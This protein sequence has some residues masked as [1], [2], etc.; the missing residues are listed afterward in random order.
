MAVLSIAPSLLQEDYHGY[1]EAAQTRKDALHKAGRTF[2]HKLA[3]EAGLPAGSYDIRSNRGGIAVS[4]EVTLH[5]DHLYVQLSEMGVGYEG[6]DVLYRS[7]KTRQDYVGG[8]NHFASLRELAKHPEQLA[9]FIREC[10]RLAQA[11]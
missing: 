7:C 11:L 3:K 2:L 6:L 8:R 5:A 1:T 10:H 9:F 4:G